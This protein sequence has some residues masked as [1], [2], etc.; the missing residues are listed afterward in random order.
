MQ[1]RPAL[2]VADIFRAHGDTYRGTHRLTHEQRG[3][4]WAIEQCRTAAL[5]GHVDVCDTCSHAVPSYNSCR[6]RHCPKCQSLAQAQWIEKRTERILP[7]HYFHIVFTLPHELGPL[8]RCNSKRVYRLLF[9]TVSRT[10]LEF[11][12]RRLHAQIGIT[13]VLH[14]WTRELQFHPHVHCIVTGGGFAVTENR[15]IAVKGRYLFPVKALSRL[16]RGK[17]LDAL[18]RAYDK[19]ELDPDRPASAI[20]APDTFQH[21]RDALYR[22]EWVVY[23]KRPFGGPERIIQYL[24]RYTHRVGIS[25]RRLVSMDDT[26]VCFTTKN[27]KTS[28]ISSP[29]FIRRFL[30]H[31]L[32]KGFVRIRHYGLMASGNSTTRLELARRSLETERPSQA[33][34]SPETTP[35]AGLA[36]GKD[37]RERF[38][39]LTG[40][41][42]SICPKCEQGRMRRYRLADLHVLNVPPADTS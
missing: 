5:G 33:T 32:P 4:M 10:L 26:R 2:E 38:T 7:T 24:G 3:V 22:K 9:E 19:G 20:A 6:D 39:E 21:L 37:W 27:G 34:H 25:N 13:A 16:F 18:A 8:T 14:T 29:E 12:Q 30:L 42:L 1:Q 15:W 36:P 40:V 41:D 23:A 31:V 11:G 28:T 17:F 35:R